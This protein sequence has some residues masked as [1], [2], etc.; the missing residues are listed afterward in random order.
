MRNILS[1][2]YYIKPISSI[3]LDY[4]VI[5]FSDAW[6]TQQLT[7]TIS[8]SDAQDKTLIWSSS[9]TSIA[10]VSQTGLVTCVTPGS[11]TITCAARHWS[12]SATCDVVQVAPVTI[13]WIYYNA[14]L[15]LISLSS[16]WE[17]WMTIADKNLWAT[18]VYNN[19][20]T[21]TQA[22]CGTYFQ[23]G[24]NYWFARTWEVTKASARVN[25]SGYW[26]WNY[27][28]SSTFITWYNDWSN[29]Q[30]DNLWGATTW[31]NEA[32]QWPS[33]SGF[34][35]PSI[36]EWQWLKT[37]MDWLS[38]TW[39]GWRTN[40]HIPFAGYRSQ[41]GATLYYQ[42]SAGYYRSS[43]PSD[44]SHARSIHLNSY[45]VYTEYDTGRRA[46]G[47]S[48]RPFKNEAVQPDTSR[49]KLY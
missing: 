49:T 41:T 1:F 37:I 14:T 5:I 13:P 28:S 30:N 32:M 31:T 20:D 6:D 19:G 9:D 10:T 46:H 47:Y 27:Y 25:A 7:A 3:V 24:N 15:W 12:A 38:L 23:W 34:H 11:C 29:V 48:V 26:P 17:T 39:D 16:D 33:P 22:N 4:N 18:T 42:G 35:V 44:A 8:P 40:L 21:L 43:S 45:S 36:S 2:H